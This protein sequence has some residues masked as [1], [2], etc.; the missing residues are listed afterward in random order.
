MTLSELRRA[1]GN[2]I[3]LDYENSGDEQNLIDEWCNQGVREVLLRT[4]CYITLGTISTTANEWQYDL[5][6]GVLVLRNVYRAGES[7]S[8]IRV[9]PEHLL[10]LQVRQTASSPDPTVV[11]WSLAG[12]N[13]FMVWPTPTAAYDMSILYVP[14][15]TVMSS[16]S[17]DP[18]STTYGGIPVELHKAIEM[19]AL[20]EAADYDDDQSTGVGQMYRERFEAEI[21]RARQQMTRKA[22]PLPPVRLARRRLAVPSRND[23][24][25]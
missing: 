24:Y 25:P 23:V 7:E 20:A 10:D 2:K 1:V 15:P 12:N 13:M 19:Y 3:G 17:H 6:N 5:A 18:S 4:H 11:Y 22:G 9:S 14:S 21:A 8:T 16:L